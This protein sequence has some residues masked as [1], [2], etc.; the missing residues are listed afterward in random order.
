M[1]FPE[2][3][4]SALVVVMAAVVLAWSSNKS[5]LSPN[6]ARSLLWTKKERY[7]RVLIV[8]LFA[9]FKYLSLTPQENGME[10]TF[11]FCSW[12]M[13][14]NYVQFCSFTFY[15]PTYHPTLVFSE[16]NINSYASYYNT[17]AY[18][19]FYFTRSVLCFAVPL[20]KIAEN[21]WSIPLL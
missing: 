9:V 7:T 5:G 12:F 19:N 21:G 4:F 1:E 18:S 3:F 20:R 15:L 2:V 17:I 10:T 13:C 11:S 16:N 14:A 6:W 8:I